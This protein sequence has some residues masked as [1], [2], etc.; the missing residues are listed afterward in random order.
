[1]SHSRKLVKRQGAFY[2]GIVS[3]VIAVLLLSSVAGFA[4]TMI[5]IGVPWGNPKFDFNGV[6]TELQE[7]Y[8]AIN[9]D[10]D[11]VFL[12]AWDREKTIAAWAGGVLPDIIFDWGNNPQMR[13]VFLPLDDLMAEKGV[14]LD[15][16]LPGSVGQM[17]ILGS[18]WTLQ[19]FIDPNFPLIYNKSLF[20]EA[21]LDPEMPPATVAEFDAMFPKL[22]RRNAEGDIVQIA[23][24]PWMWAFDRPL[25]NAL[26]FGSAFG[27]TLWEG[28]ETEG[29]LGLTSP[30]MVEA[31]EWIKS[32]YDEYAV[33][34]ANLVPETFGHVQGRMTNGTQAMYLWTT[35]ELHLLRTNAPQYEWGVAPPFHKEDGGFEYPIW[36]GGWSAGVTRQ[37]QNQEAAFDFLAFM[38]YSPEGQEILARVGELFP[39]TKESPG[40]AALVETEPA[41]FNFI[42]AIRQ[43]TLSPATYWLDLRWD[44]GF[45]V[46]SQRIFREG[47][48]PID[49]LREVENWLRL[50]ADELGV[51]IL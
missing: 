33:S 46:V 42:P 34:A 35:P 8:T 41:W 40:F 30:Q 6:F 19:I 22:T 47:I 11:I 16:Y 29:R 9:P 51:T 24:P 28:S 39:A 38:S 5:T 17:H 20:A 1:M 50:D 48:A 36:F 32:Y 23:M 43:S 21:G 12:P 49:A 13:E 44:A 7:A 4:K 25:L 18:T 2:L 45:S 15:D 10:V 37:S 27:A 26:T 14:L 3:I 31:Y